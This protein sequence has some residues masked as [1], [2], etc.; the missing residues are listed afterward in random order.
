V[1]QGPL[2][3]FFAGMAY[4]ITND[5]F[6]ATTDRQLAPMLE[7]IFNAAPATTVE[8]TAYIG[9]WKDIFD[10]V[11]QDFQRGNPDLSMTYA[12][13]FQ[14]LVGAYE[15]TNLSLSIV[16]AAQVF[17][18][19]DEI[20]KTA[21]AKWSAPAITEYS[22]LIR[23]TKPPKETPATTSMSSA[24]ISVMTSSTTRFERTQSVSRI[25]T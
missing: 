6:R 3:S 5:T 22:I 10:V 16:Q 1:A 21:P 14:N 13:L 12:Y 9:Q 17:D 23:L 24:A 20:I 11:L 15:N 18:I 8:A 7:Q 19:P 25:R 2:A 4:D